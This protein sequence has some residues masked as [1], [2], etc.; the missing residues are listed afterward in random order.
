MIYNYPIIAQK[1]PMLK[2]VVTTINTEFILTSALSQLPF[3]QFRPYANL[4]P[5]ALMSKS[6]SPWRR[7]W[8]IHLRSRPPLTQ[9]S[10]V[11]FRMWV[12]WKIGA[13]IL[14]KRNMAEKDVCR[15]HMFRS[16]GCNFSFCRDFLHHWWLLKVKKE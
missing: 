14:F 13:I 5:R 7:V 16:L 12:I 4:V 11:L 6:K 15:A 2:Q 8:A 3:V 9:G 10:R 1:L